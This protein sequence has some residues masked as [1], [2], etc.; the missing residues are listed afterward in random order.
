MSVTY[1]DV[2]KLVSIIDDKLF[3]NLNTESGV[4][5]LS[6]KIYQLFMCVNVDIDRQFLYNCAVYL[7]QFC[8]IEYNKLENDYEW[9]NE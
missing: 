1:L 5:L 3:F 4:L 9:K 2:N 7:S 8:K 6:N